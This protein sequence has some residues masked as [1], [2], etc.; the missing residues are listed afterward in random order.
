MTKAK[1]YELMTHKVFGGELYV[2]QVEAGKA[3][4]RYITSTGELKRETF[5][6]DELIDYVEPANTTVKGEGIARAGEATFTTE[7]IVD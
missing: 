3:D 5:L 6:V 1:E 7:G 4:C 2:I